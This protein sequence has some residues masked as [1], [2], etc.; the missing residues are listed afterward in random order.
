MGW[1][2]FIMEGEAPRGEKSGNLGES[3]W[4]CQALQNGISRMFSDA[5]ALEINSDL[6][7]PQNPLSISSLVMVRAA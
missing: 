6:K 4:F 2:I 7:N 3:L 5:K 1:G